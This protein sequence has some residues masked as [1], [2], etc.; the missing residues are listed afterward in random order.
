[1]ISLIVESKISELSELNLSTKQK[2][3]HSQAKGGE[4][5]WSGNLG[6]VD[7]NYRI[8]NG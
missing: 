5:G 6:L 2:Q 7:V 3:T 8:Q 1:M 4:E